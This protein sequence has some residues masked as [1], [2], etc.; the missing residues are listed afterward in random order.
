MKCVVYFKFTTTYNKGEVK[1]LN[2]AGLNGANVGIKNAITLGN[3]SGTNKDGVIM[4]TLDGVILDNVYYPNIYT[5]KYGVSFDKNALTKD[6]IKGILGDTYWNY[7]TD[8]PRLYK[9]NVSVSDNNI[10]SIDVT[11]EILN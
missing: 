6:S 11:G 4:H 3:I 2:S 9:V 7:D 5:S 8:T 10:S 1:G